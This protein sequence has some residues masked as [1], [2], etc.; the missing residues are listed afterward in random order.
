MTD[1]E[2]KAA[3]KTRRTTRLPPEERKQMLV[4][5][6]ADFF[7]KEGFDAGTRV[8]AEQM[9]ITQPLIY[10]Y[11]DSKDD[12]INEVYRHVYVSQW[13]DSWAETLTDRT[14]PLRGRLLDFYAAYCPV[15]FNERWMR[16]FFF[17]GLKGLDINSRYIQRVADLLLTPIC[18]E[19]RA[20]LGYKTD[21]PITEDEL[22]LVWLMH[23]TVFYQG[24][25]EK[26]YRSVEAVNYDF[27]V[28]T[29]VDMYLRVAPEVLARAVRKRPD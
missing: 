13:Q 21:V 5:K 26:I 17:A 18:H 14:R 29:A 1:S 28:R 22:E 19:M 2:P 20:E 10:R 9:G 23:G 24:V 6:A 3:A 27:A 4:Q 16:I 7:S 25:R 12:L 11:F 8:L 15:V